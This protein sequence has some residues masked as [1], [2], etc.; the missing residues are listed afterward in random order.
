MNM[1]K[2]TI[3]CTLE[4]MKNALELNAP[5]LRRYIDN[6]QKCFYI[7]LESEFPPYIIPTAEQMIGWLEEKGINVVVEREYEH[8]IWKLWDGRC[9]ILDMS[10]LVWYDTRDEATLTAID[11]ALKYLVDCN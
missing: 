1:E 2:Y 10:E 6:G 7:D 8:Y 9:N 11:A 5:I 3:Y 4:Q